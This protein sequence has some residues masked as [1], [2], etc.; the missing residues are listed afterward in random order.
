MI[1]K[2]WWWFGRD[3]RKWFLEVSLNQH[4][5]WFTGL[6]I[7]RAFCLK[8]CAVLNEVITIS[9]HSWSCSFG[10]GWAW[11]KYITHLISLY[12]Y[13]IKIPHLAQKSLKILVT[14]TKFLT[15][16]LDAIFVA[17]SFS[18]FFF[19]HES[20]KLQAHLHAAVGNYSCFN[21][22]LLLSSYHF[23]HIRSWPAKIYLFK[24]SHLFW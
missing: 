16:L 8:F 6:M 21:Y 23:L 19:G 22:M 13:C 20:M 4:L 2:G 5:G 7:L 9:F 12:L 10:V 18:Q 1:Q 24:I 3:D 15:S 17:Q 11:Q 14:E